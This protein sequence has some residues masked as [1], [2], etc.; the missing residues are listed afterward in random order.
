MFRLLFVLLAFVGV[1]LIVGLPA[2]DLSAGPPV[3]GRGDAYI[4]AARCASCHGPAFETW[5]TKDPHARAHLSLPPERRNDAKCTGCH[6]PDPGGVFAGVQCESCHGAGGGYSFAFVMKDKLLA[7]AL[8]MIDADKARCVTCHSG[9][10]APK[11]FDYPRALQK[12]VHW[13]R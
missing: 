9:H 8:G 13:S 11:P 2:R 6:S 12:I 5:R 1:G 3:P 7:K 4:G 10:G